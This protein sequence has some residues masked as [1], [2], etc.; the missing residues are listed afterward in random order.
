MISYRSIIAPT[1]IRT[2]PAQYASK[3]HSRLASAAHLSALAFLPASTRHVI[4]I[5]ANDLIETYAWDRLLFAGI[6][7]PIPL[8]A[9]TLGTSAGQYKGLIGL[10]GRAAANVIFSETKEV[11]K[12]ADGVG[13]P[14]PE[15]HAGQVGA[16]EVHL[17]QVAMR[18]PMICDVKK[19]RKVGLWDEE[20]GALGIND[21]DVST[22]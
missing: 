2:H 14:L 12:L 1:D 6:T 13:E 10:S 15:S 22:L 17:R 7:S 16:G 8:S 3:A 11:A 4:I 5:T 20:V 21:L 9:S 18:S 19:A